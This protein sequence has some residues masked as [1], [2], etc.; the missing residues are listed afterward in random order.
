M[1][2]FDR[3][4]QQITAFVAACHRLAFLRMVVSEGGNCAWRLDENCI[5]IT[6]TRREKQA[7][8]PEDLVFIDLRGNVL[9]GGRP[10]GET[11]IYLKFFTQRPDVCSI[12]HC[13]PP[14]A[15][16]AAIMKGRNWLERPFF[17]EA[18]IEV[19]PVPLVPY[20]QPLSQRLAD[21]FDPFLQKYNCFLMQ[22]H[23][24]VAMTSGDIGRALMTVE[25][26]EATAC[27]LVAALQCGDINELDRTA[28]AELDEVMRIRNLPL[29][30]APGLNR[31]LVDLYFA[32]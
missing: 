12:I 24:V 10:T 11:P 4:H 23:G 20:A 28:V 3:Y 32:G 5:L 25:L 13:H 6:P 15:C 21:Q 26:L 22:N 31:S 19:G 29:F 27:S 7:L 18:V 9:A 30:G 1:S 8:T 16:A 2:L 14:F 17:P